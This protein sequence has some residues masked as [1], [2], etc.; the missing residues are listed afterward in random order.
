MVS[1]KENVLRTV[2][3]L[4]YFPWGMA[5]DG[6]VETQPDPKILLGSQI[7]LETLTQQLSS[8]FLLTF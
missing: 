7:L 3:Y 6:I 2:G 4:S 5:W 1:E 8:M